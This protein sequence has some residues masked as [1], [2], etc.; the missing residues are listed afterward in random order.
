MIQKPNKEEIVNMNITLACI[1]H[2]YHYIS[3][4]GGSCHVVTDDD[5]IEDDDLKWCIDYCD[6]EDAKESYDR[7]LCKFICEQ[8]LRLKREYRIILLNMFIRGCHL[9]DED[10]IDVYF[11]TTDVDELVRSYDDIAE[12]RGIE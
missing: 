8:L 10:I 9:I 6:S 1:N 7:H 2:L 12:A 3:G 11:K 4:A 5:N